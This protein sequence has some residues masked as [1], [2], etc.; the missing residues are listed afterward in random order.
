M[1]SAIGWARNLATWL[2]RLEVILLSAIYLY[3]VITDELPVAAFVILAAIWLARWW[4]MG[5]LTRTTVL[6][7]P[8][9]LV[10]LLLPVTLAVSTNW[11]VSLPKVY[12][13]LLSIAFYF[14]VVNGVS[15]RGDLAWAIFWFVLVS[16]AIALAGL[17]GTDWA[18]SKI[19][20]ASVV[21]DRLPH[22]IQGIPRSI[23]GGFARN[24]VGG[25]VALLIPFLVAL[26]FARPFPAA[27]LPPIAR[28]WFGR[29]LLLALVLALG[30][31]A[32]TQSRGGLLAAAVGLSGVALWRERRFA[33]VAA[34]GVTIVLS[35]VLLG[36]GTAFADTLLRMD[37]GGGT[38][39]SR[40]EVWQRGIWM[41]Q[42]F[43]FSGI[44]IGTYNETAHRLYPFFIAR[45][46]EVVAHSHNNLLQVAVD[47]GIPG[48]VAYV[49]MVTAFAICLLRAYRSTI[50]VGVRALSIGLGA[51]MLAHQVFGVT[52]A[53]ML[54]TKPGVLLW[55]FLGMAVVLSERKELAVR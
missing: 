23:A 16:S 30:A 4:T 28:Q 39:A 34:A 41:V 37:T 55:V 46:D 2:V 45:P 22:F 11:W 49:A 53:F 25:T 17:V 9:F 31:L 36:Q 40:L 43:P 32:L 54:G 20:S 50:D 7:L 6:D 19:I 8:I 1:N 47:M 13:L 5:R 29:L 24:G 10:L 3:F 12:G 38:F 33:W 18:Q 27:D 14:A 26:V 15:S 48:L 44:G 21:Y 42:D 52:D 35:L 51:G